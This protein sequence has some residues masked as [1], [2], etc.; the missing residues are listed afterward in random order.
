M[1]KNSKPINWLARLAFKTWQPPPE[2]TLSQWADEKF[3]LSPESSAEPG[4]WRTYPYQRGPMD[5]MTDP[6]IERV[7]FRKSAR[8]GYTK[9]VNIAIGYHIEQDPCPQLVVQPT[10][11]DAQGYSKDE[12]APMI[13]DC[14]C[15][16]GRVADA[17]SRDSNNTI[18]KKAYP[19]G[20]LTLIGANSARGFRRLTV[21][22]IYFDEVNGYP[23]TAGHE[24][25]Q[26]TLGVKRTDTFWNRKIIMGSTDTI[27]GMSRIEEN[28]L[29]S[30]QRLCLVPC[31]HCDHFQ[32]LKFANL[33]WPKDNPERAYFQCTRCK[34]AIDHRSKRAMIDRCRWQ[35]TAKAKAKRHAGF[36]IWSAYSFA[37]AAAWGLI[38]TRFMDANQ[39]F[40]HTADFEKLKTFTNTDLGESWEEKGQGVETIELTKNKD[41]IADTVHNDVLVITAGV[42]IQDDRIELE[43]VGWAANR[44]SWSLAWEVLPGDTDRQ[45]VWNQLDEQLQRRF[46]R[47][48][49]APDMPVNCAV[50]DHGHKTAMVETFVLPRQIRRIYAG[51]GSSIAGKPI[52]TAPGRQSKALRKKIWLITIGTDTCK[53]LIMGRLRVTEPGPGFCHFPD[54]RPEEYFKQLTAEE[55]VHRYQKG[56]K[57]RIWKKKRPRNEALDLRVYAT[58]AL[59]V[60]NP[61][62]EKIRTNLKRRARAEQPDAGQPEPKPKPKRR[63][64]RRGF[65]N[66]W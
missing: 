66:A 32:A 5:A 18:M 22:N 2:L 54:D 65:V 38:A 64:K 55:V 48:D 43:I 1:S 57:K 28:Y 53:D 51:K 3:Y 45:D 10:I 19:G 17:K 33:K 12:I 16:D 29:L 14:P 37:P 49:G 34:K 24:G 26:I 47:A 7:T 39:Y 20:V 25:D 21:R 63:K 27:K 6:R 62:F 60:L 52:A 23:P 11:D 31:P 35:A 30:D 36:F 50:V 58:A 8:V 9:M 61:K 40:K 15:L 59:E 41:A 13:R 56:V 4:K 46:A 44:E 42:D